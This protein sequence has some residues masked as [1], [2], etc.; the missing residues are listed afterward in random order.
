MVADGELDP[1]IVDF[2]MS[3]GV[4]DDYAHAE[5]SPEQRDLVFRD[6]ASKEAS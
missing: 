5:V 3:S 2:A 1:D 6:L 4:F